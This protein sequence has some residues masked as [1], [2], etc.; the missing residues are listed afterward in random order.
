MPYSYA[1]DRL[2]KTLEKEFPMKYFLIF[3][4]FLILS[5]CNFEVSNDTISTTPTMNLCQTFAAAK[6]GNATEAS[7]QLAAEEIARRGQFTDSE[8]E[9]IAQGR[10]K[11]GMSEQAGLCAWGGYWRDL[12]TTNVSGAVTKQYI[13]GDPQYGTR[14][15]LYT[16][17]GVVTAT[18]E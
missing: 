2:Q 15:Y 17:N 1:Y 18:Q 6:V 7:G 12:N 8:V 13:F 10:A 14:R 9:L 3:P 11:P 4:A 16:R 5:G